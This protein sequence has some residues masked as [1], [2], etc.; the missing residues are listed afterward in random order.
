MSQQRK[1]SIFIFKIIPKSLL[2]RLFGY[3]ARIPLPRFIMKKMIPW[4]S[5]RYGVLDEYVTPQKGFKSF[6]HFFTR[7]LKDGARE[8]TSAPKVI[9]SPVDARVDQFGPIESGTLIQA[10]GISYKI[11]DLIPSE[12]AEQFRNGSFMTL[13]LSP[14]D[15][16]RIHCPV[17]GK[18]TGFFNLPGRLYTV[19]EYMVEG[20]PGL[21]NKNERVITYVESDNGTVGICKVG[22][23]NVGR[24]SLS[25]TGKGHTYKK[26]IQSNNTFR[27]RKEILFTENDII[28]V[29]AGDELGIF[30]LGSTVILT[31][32]KRCAF[33]SHLNLGKKVKMGEEI[34]TF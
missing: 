31:F 21:F 16:H 4:Y 17:G 33:S 14:G 18:I 28:P 15:Y 30:N 20:L 10:K 32:Q 12:M 1:L 24:I 7:I 22:A 26:Y 9:V 23:T 8:I 6:N 5:K 27:F 3:V 34:G 29:K 2:S 11:D 25:Y 19:Q 13:Y